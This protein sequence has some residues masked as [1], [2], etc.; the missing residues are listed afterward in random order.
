MKDCALSK[1]EVQ[2]DKCMMIINVLSL[3]GSP[4][5][6]DMHLKTLF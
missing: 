5:V 4:I 2:L 6:E 3:G 1:C